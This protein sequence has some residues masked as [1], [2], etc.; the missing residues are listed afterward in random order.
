MHGT[1]RRGR[2]N[3]PLFR[4]LLSMIGEDWEKVHEEAVERLDTAEP[5]F[6]MVARNEHE[7][8]PYI[9]TEN[10]IF[11]GL[12]VDGAGN[13]AKVAPDLRNEDLMPHCSCCTHTFNGVALVEEYKPAT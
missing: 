2:D 8:T 13:L 11:S 9:R 4:F 12:Y 1:K 7:K 3:T 5:I 6:W 10:A